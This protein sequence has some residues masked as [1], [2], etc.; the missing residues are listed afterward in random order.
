MPLASLRAVSQIISSKTYLFLQYTLITYT[1]KNYFFDQESTPFHNAQSHFLIETIAF[2][3]KY[4][5]ISLTV[6][7]T[8]ATSLIQGN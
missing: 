1:F 4:I 2:H 7:Y 8:D 3:L 5:I 6:S